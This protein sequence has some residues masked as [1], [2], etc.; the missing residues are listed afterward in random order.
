MALVIGALIR[1]DLVP[2]WIH[3]REIAL[4]DKATDLLSQMTAAMDRNTKALDTV[5]G[6][7]TVV[8]G[9]LGRGQ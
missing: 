2:G 9:L 1:G 4:G 6:Q 8:V 7:Q 3:K 5:V